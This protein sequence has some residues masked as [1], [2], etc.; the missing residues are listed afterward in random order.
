MTVLQLIF[1]AFSAVAIFSGLM[2]V[3]SSNPVRGALFL[4]LSFFCMAGLWI[5]LQAEFLALI[6][7]L[8]YVGAVMTLFLFVVMMLSVNRVSVQEGFV[9]YLPVC[10]L[11]VLMIVGLMIMVVGPERFGLTQIP[12]P[13]AFPA[14]YS[15]MVSLGEVLYTDYVFPFEVAAV[16]L[17]TAIIAA[18]SLTHRQSKKHKSQN[19]SK[20][21]AVKAGDR[22]RIVK[23]PSEPKINPTGGQ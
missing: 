15:N 23:M 7:V 21:I 13:A 20:Q 6:L 10:A 22:L 8:V 9:R 16:I 11:I 17:L 3:G 2:V 5:L 18:I 4:V 12:M 1:Y 19:I 14:D